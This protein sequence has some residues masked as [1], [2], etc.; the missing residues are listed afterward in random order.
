MFDI[1]FFMFNRPL[2]L[3]KR[4]EQTNS[5]FQGRHHIS[6]LV[7]EF[8]P[9]SRCKYIRSFSAA[10]QMESEAPSIEFERGLSCISSSFSSDPPAHTSSP[11]LVATQYTQRHHLSASQSL[12]P[13]QSQELRGTE[14]RTTERTTCIYARQQQQQRCKNTFAIF[15]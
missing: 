7:G 3:Y 5:G 1:T 11:A 10:Q 2:T 13:L 12:P 15:H 9:L 14:K 6:S 4:A 8:L